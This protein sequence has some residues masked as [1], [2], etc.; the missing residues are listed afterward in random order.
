MDQRAADRLVEK[1]RR[2]VSEELDD[3]ERPLFAALIA[4]GVA[5]AYDETEVE[6][7]E[8]VEWDRAALPDSLVR[9][10]RESGIRVEGLDRS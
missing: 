2:F 4:P 7:F 9:S 3:D 5:R 1:I 8:A 10:L 6:A